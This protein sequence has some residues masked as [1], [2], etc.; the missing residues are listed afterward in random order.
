MEK[1][2]TPESKQQNQWPKFSQAVED[3]AAGF[4]SAATLPEGSESKKN[5]LDAT[6][7]KLERLVKNEKFETVAD[8]ADLPENLKK[9]LVFIRRMQK[10]YFPETI[11]PHAEIIDESDLSIDPETGEVHEAVKHAWAHG[12]KERERQAAGVEEIVDV[13]LEETT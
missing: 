2:K 8:R 10:Q 13:D 1:P 9:N 3:I 11:I 6:L 7:Q 5:T 4:L 12:E